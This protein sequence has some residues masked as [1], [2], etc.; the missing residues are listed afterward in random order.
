MGWWPSKLVVILNIIIL[1]GYSMIGLVISGQI[2]SAVSS[3]NSMSIVV[4][5]YS[6]MS[7]IDFA[8]CTFRYH[9]SCDH[10]FLRHHIRHTGLPQLRAVRILSTC[11]VSVTDRQN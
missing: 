4:G 8:D 1:L 2:L 6:A 11:S 9:S 7:C 5:P 10:C 3:N